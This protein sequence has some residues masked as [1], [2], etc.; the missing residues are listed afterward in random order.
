MK[1]NRVI[2]TIG[3]AMVVS[4]TALAAVTTVT[5]TSYALRPCSTC[6]EVAYPTEAQC[7]A[8]GQAEARRVGETRTTGS[9][10]YTCVVRHNVIATFR[11]DTVTCPSASAPRVQSC[12]A[13]TTG[14]W[15]QTA[16]VGPAPACAVTWSPLAAPPGACTT[17]PPSGTATLSWTPPTRNTDGSAL[18]NLAGY[19]IHYG[20][21]A[22]ELSQTIQIAD[23]GATRYT[24]ERLSAGTWHFAVRAYNSAG[25]ESDP[26]N[27]ISKAV[28]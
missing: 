13:G 26:S 8:A 19:R 18:N 11:A 25:G 22:G 17:P 21:S 7:I 27:T 9:A 14:S 10:V 3:L 6:K 12:P 4:G 24:I 1:F 28:P 2:L 15:S 23:A 16:T 5:S 20:R